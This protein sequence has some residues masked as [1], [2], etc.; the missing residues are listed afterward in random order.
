MIGDS[1]TRQWHQAV[2]ILATGDFATGGNHL[3]DC[4]CD[5]QFSESRRCRAG[6]Y[7]HRRISE[8]QGRRVALL[9]DMTE[10][11]SR[12]HAFPEFEVSNDQNLSAVMRRWSWLRSLCVNK[13]RPIVLVLQAGLHFKVNFAE[14][15]SAFFSPLLQMARGVGC[16]DTVLVTGPTIQSKALDKRFPNQT[17]VRVRTFNSRLGEWATSEN[18]TALDFTEATRSEPTSDGVHFLTSGNVLKATVLLHVLPLI[19]R[20]TPTRTQSLEP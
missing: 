7:H 14:A 19:K 13:D 17:E 3:M 8:G 5:G 2:Q 10:V 12:P 9:Y 20:V 1:T 18:L 4:R 15:Q 6:G 16:V 11:G